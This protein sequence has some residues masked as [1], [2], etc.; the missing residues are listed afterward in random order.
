MNLGARGLS[1]LSMLSVSMHVSEID[2]WKRDQ[3]FRPTCF[4]VMKN[5]AP[6]SSSVTTSWSRIVSDPMPANTRFLATSLANARMVM[7]RMLADRN[8][9]NCQLGVVW[10]CLVRLNYFSCALTPHNLICLSYSAISSEYRGL[11]CNH[12]K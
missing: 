5:C 6:R 9:G 8:L 4:S 11:A 7:R 3:T 1:A 10:E 2:G 12:Q